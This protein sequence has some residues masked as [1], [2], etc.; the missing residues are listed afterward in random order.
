MCIID[1]TEELAMR[2]HGEGGVS[3]HDNGIQICL[4][5]NKNDL[6]RKFNMH[7][8]APKTILLERRPELPMGK[9]A[10]S[11]TCRERW[12]RGIDLSIVVISA[13]A[14]CPPQLILIG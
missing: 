14:K 9:H 12:F 5:R 1:R 3:A 6:L 8:Y 7:S 13:R 10:I 11:E 2:Y 4:L